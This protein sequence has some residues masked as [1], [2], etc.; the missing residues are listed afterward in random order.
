M[1]ELRAGAAGQQRAE[2]ESRELLE[3]E[4]GRG[5]RRPVPAGPGRGK[6]GVVTTVGASGRG[7]TLSG[8]ELRRGPPPSPGSEQVKKAEGG[9]GQ[10]GPR[11]CR[12]R[13]HRDRCFRICFLMIP[14]M[15]EPRPAW[16]AGGQL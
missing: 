11:D 16:K 5:L 8:L 6:N 9:G 1:W 4:E 15:P 3:W 2:K 12:W 7:E 13:S 14:A 10:E